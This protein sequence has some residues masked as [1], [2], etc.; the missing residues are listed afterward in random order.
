VVADR[1]RREGS[2]RERLKLFFLRRVLFNIW[3]VA[4]RLHIRL[5]TEGPTH[6]PPDAQLLEMDALVARARVDGGVIDGSSLAYPAHELL[7]HLVLRYGLL[8]HGT[9]NRELEVI[10]PRR[11]H[12]F[13]THVEAVVAADDGIW[14]LFYA[15]VARDRVE[16]VF[17]ACLHVGRPPRQRRFYMFRVFGA[18]PHKGTT[19]THGAVYAVQRAGFWREWGNEWLRSTGVTP[20]LRV[21]V[22][23]SDFPLRHV[24]SSSRAAPS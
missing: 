13:G 23:P 19:W 15:V 2:P 4:E 22:R 10:E 11:A 9:N 12:D 3:R 8:L 1:G 14:P 7:T 24:V 16:G 5:S 17:T 18:D 20:V 6:A 21:L